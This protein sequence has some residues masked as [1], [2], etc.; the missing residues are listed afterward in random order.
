MSDYFFYLLA[1]L[2]VLGHPV[3]TSVQLMENISETTK[4]KAPTETSSYPP[5]TI[6]QLSETTASMTQN[7]MKT[8]TTKKTTPINRGCCPT[9]QIDCH[10]TQATGTSLLSMNISENMMSNCPS[11]NPPKDGILYLALLQEVNQTAKDSTPTPPTSTQAQPQ[12]VFTTTAFTK[13]RTRNGE[14]VCKGARVIT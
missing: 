3:S 12:A 2:I 14:L 9:V 1:L 8:T 13:L 6:S 11:K 5:N 10:Q 7:S 4:I